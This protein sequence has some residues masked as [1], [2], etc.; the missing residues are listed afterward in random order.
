MTAPLVKEM[1]LTAEEFRRLLPGAAGDL[2]VRDEG[3]VVHVG[4]AVEIALEPLPPRRLGLLA[5]PVMRVTLS[6]QG[7]GEDEVRAFAQRFDRAFQKGG[8]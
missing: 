5:I 6:F 7:W 1:A 3:A 8:G 2:R 4:D